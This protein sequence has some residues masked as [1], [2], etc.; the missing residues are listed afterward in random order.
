MKHTLLT[1]AITS[2]LAI[3]AL[4]DPIHD[5]AENGNLAGV[6][7]ELDK[8]VDVNA[9]NRSFYDL[10]PLHYAV[11]KG[12]AELLITE[13]ADVNALAKEGSTPLHFAAWNGYKEIA[14]ILIDNGADLN[15][16]NN[17]FAGTPFITALDW[18]IQRGKTETSDLLRKHGGMTAAELRSGMTPLHAASRKGLKEVVELL[19]HEGAD[20]NAKIAAGGANKN[21]TP[22]DFANENN[23]SEIADLLRKH[24]AKTREEL[25]VLFD[26]AKNGDIEAVKKHLAAGANVNAKDVEGRA[27]MHNAA[28]YGQKKVAELLIDNAADVNARIVSGRYKGQTPLDFAI[29]RK[30]SEIADLLRKYGGKTGEELLMPRLEYGK[31]QWPF[32]FSFTAEEGMIYLVEVTQDFKQWAELETIEGTGELV[33]FTDPRQPLMPFKRNFYRVKVVD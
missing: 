27:P 5:A 2:L 21:K 8:G 14:Q 19:I 29:R 26:A 17:E 10:V 15:V 7:A 33:K 4:A 24:G 23:K 22:L 6:Q 31:D 28:Y 32:G 25:H 1:L 18:A 16:I 20:V 11:T 3:N 9:L 12:V 13:G 30:K